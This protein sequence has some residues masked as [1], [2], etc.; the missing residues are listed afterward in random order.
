MQ[1]LRIIEQSDSH[2]VTRGL[3]AEEMAYVIAS[4]Y[5]E[6]DDAQDDKMEE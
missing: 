1:L 6:S 3:T 4:Y 2:C 5:A